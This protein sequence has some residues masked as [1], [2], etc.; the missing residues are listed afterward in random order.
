MVPSRLYRAVFRRV[1]EMPRRTLPYVSVLQLT[2]KLNLFLAA[3][4]QPFLRIAI[5][6][7]TMIFDLL[8]LYHGENF[9]VIITMTF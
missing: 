9:L 6:R 7:Y 1:Y 2:N 3:C 4:Q 8:P 5:S